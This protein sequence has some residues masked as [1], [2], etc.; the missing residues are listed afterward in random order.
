MIFPVLNESEGAYS[1]GLCFSFNIT[2]V[3]LRYA[4]QLVF[5]YFI[6]LGTMLKMFKILPAKHSSGKQ[7]SQFQSNIDQQ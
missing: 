7:T 5:T 3:W 1:E 4:G 6:K 2:L